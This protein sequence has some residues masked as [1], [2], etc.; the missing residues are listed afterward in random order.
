MDKIKKQN[1]EQIFAD[2]FAKYSKYI[3]LERALPDIRDGLKPVQRRIVYAMY[4]ERNSYENN[5]RK[6][7]KTVG[8]VIGNYHPH[9][10][11]S[12][13]DA[14]IRMSQDW[15]LRENLIE[16]H[17]NN[18]SMDGDSPAAMRY[19]E[20][21]MSKIADFLTRDI[22]KNTVDFI[23]N[24]DDTTKEPLVLPAIFPNFLVNGGS[25]IAAGYATDVPT[26]NP[27]EVIQTIIHRIKNPN[28]RLDTLLKIFKGPDFPTG[29]QIFFETPIEE[30]YTTGKG[31][32]TLYPKFTVSKNEIIITE[33]PYEV[34]K[35]D[36]VKSIDQIRLSGSLPQLKLVRDD[37]DRNGISI[38]IK[39]DDPKNIE[40]VKK[41]LYKKTN[42]SK[43]YNLNMVGIVNNKP[44]LLSLELI[45]DTYIGHQQEVFKNKYNFLLSKYLARHHIVAGLIKSV[46]ILDEVIAIIRSSFD[47]KEAKEKLISKYDFSEIQSEAIVMM[48]LHQLSNTD[49]VDLEKESSDLNEK[50]TNLKL[51]LGN[52]NLLNKEIIIELKN[53]LKIKEISLDRRSLISDS[54]EDVTIE[55]DNLIPSENVVVSITKNNYIK[56]S[57]LKSYKSSIKVNFEEDCLI[58]VVETNTKHYLLAFSS[59]GR[60]ISLP[61]HKI[62]NEVFKKHGS[63]ISSYFDLKEN[64]RIIKYIIINEFNTTKNLIITTNKNQIKQVAINDFNSKKVKS[65]IKLKSKDTYVTNVLF[66]HDELV[67]ISNNG[68]IFKFKTE[69]IPVTSLAASGVKI[70]NITSEEE[71][72][73][74][75]SQRSLL[76]LFKNN[77]YKRISSDVVNEQKRGSKGK[78]SYKNLKS[79]EFKVTSIT[80]LNNEVEYVNENKLELSPISKF[81]LSDLESKPKKLDSNIEVVTGKVE[82]IVISKEENIEKGIS[83]VKVVTTKKKKVPMQDILNELDEQKNKSGSNE[84][85]ISDLVTNI[86]GD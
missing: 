8:N 17:G 60:F 51:L 54:K 37:S 53:L 57:S 31:K 24:F 40:I 75:S 86:L 74:T 64:E 45:I 38:C 55:E 6:S 62:N 9:G 66:N 33:L 21:K 73:V 80:S 48:R 43:S 47:K 81:K 18:G 50:I 58:K 69:Q 79:I 5:Y 77:M 20:A 67:S 59:L 65:Y 13:Y 36:L 16:I 30:I 25:G 2:R 72:F 12:I 26:H 14:M 3:I 34:N 28:S 61:I 23:P 1:I 56:R 63:H 85:N 44:R 49:L 11:S 29:G 39:V 83:D 35:A 22:E 68:N 71:T 4:K 84:E 78:S 76:L 15:K 42:L 19:T 27:S 7:A 41:Y 46:S 52:I 10:D 70:Q 82:K 32:L